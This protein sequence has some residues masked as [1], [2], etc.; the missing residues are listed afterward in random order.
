MK[1]AYFYERAVARSGG[2]EALQKRLPMIATKAELEARDDS[3]YLAEITRCVFRA[4]FVWRII[5][6]K[7]P[8]FEAAFSGFVPVYWQQVPPERLDAL[9]GD[10]RIVRNMQKIDTVPLNARMIVEA[11]EEY[12]SFGRFLSQWPSSDQAELLI[13]L[14]NSGSR[15]GGVTAQY[16]LRRVGYDGFVL[17]A[18]VVTALE[19]H[20]LMDASPTSKKGLLQAQ[21][22]F[23]QW[24]AETGLPYSHLSKILSCTL[25]AVR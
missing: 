3:F 5:D 13:W 25:D 6:H 19:N 8:G 4:G 2:E 7:W 17:S 10:E 23:N 12:G 9:S 18:D 24:H 14:K 1:F 20:N 22:A 21:K 16:F 15:L 11:S